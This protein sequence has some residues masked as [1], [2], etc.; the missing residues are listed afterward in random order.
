MS[1]RIEILIDHDKWN[2]HRGL[3]ARMK[4]AAS[5][6]LRRGGAT[7]R[8]AGVTILLAGDA[9]LRG[10]NKRFRGKNKTTN[11]LSFAA[12]GEE[13]HLGDI[14]IAYGLAAR[15]ARGAG[16]SLRDHAVHLVV[17]GTLHLLGFDHTTARA[18]ARMEPLEV[19]ILAELGI[20]DPY[21]QRAKAA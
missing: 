7:K 13:P 12:T 14:A 21:A 8:S 16:K 9:R 15:E 17:H 6:A 20:A 19:S 11:V 10:L 18:A 4:Q 1:G 5:L 2:A 3:R